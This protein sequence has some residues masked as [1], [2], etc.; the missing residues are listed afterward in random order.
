MELYGKKTDKGNE[1][2][3]VSRNNQGRLCYERVDVKKQKEFKTMQSDK[4][5]DSYIFNNGFHLITTERATKFGDFMKKGELMSEIKDAIVKGGE[6][7]FGRNGA[8][9]TGWPIEQTED[10][11][12][13][14]VNAPFAQKVVRG[15]KTVTIPSKEIII[16][17]EGL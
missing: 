17:G 1:C 16:L 2:L 11:V 12:T 8:I 4:Q 5:M 7:A 14:R 13:I 15:Y 6:V 9:Y 10:H 3:Y